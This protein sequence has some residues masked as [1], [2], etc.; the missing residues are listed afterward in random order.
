MNRNEVKLVFDNVAD[1][2]KVADQYG[3]YGNGVC[4]DY[5]NIEKNDDNYESKYEITIQRSEIEDFGRIGEDARLYGAE[6][7]TSIDD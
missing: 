6:V 1:R 7:Q 5:A 2:D 3:A 4:S